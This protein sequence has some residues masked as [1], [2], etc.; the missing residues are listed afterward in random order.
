MI[1]RFGGR[2]GSIRIQATVR[3]CLFPEVTALKGCGAN[4]R[5]HARGPDR[6]AGL[7]RPFVVILNQA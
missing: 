5:L 3:C 1:K 2:F 7:T 4:L 6:T